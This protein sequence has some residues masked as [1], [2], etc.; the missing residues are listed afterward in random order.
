MCEYKNCKLCPR[1][2]GIDRSKT[3]GACK[4]TDKVKVA[5][6][7]I[8]SYEEP[9]ISGIEGSGTVFFSNCNLR[10]VYCQNFE[11]SRDGFGKEITVERLA[12]IF[13]EQQS[14]GVNNIN[15]VTPTMYVDSI[16]EAI[17]IAKSK[18]LIIPIVYNSS[19]YEKAETIKKLEGYIDVYL[20]DF[21]YATN[22]LA[23]KYSGVNNYVESVIPAIRE[24]IRQAGKPIFNDKGIMTKGVI[25]RHMILPNNVLNTKMVLKKVKEEFKDNTLI[26]VMAQY[27]PSG[28]AA[29]YPEINR[30]ITAEEL[31][32]VENY[33]EEL[34]MDNGYIQEL[35]EHEEEYVPNFDLSNI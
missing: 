16:I 30:K 12:D 20:P 11:I 21:K 6:A 9:C 7:S 25:I 35:G 34:E 14:R 13:I 33:L 18:G 17:K 4:A 23:K 27:F 32:E 26:S 22:R 31:E 8:H 24:M 1:E 28:D 5:L 10:C 3:I 2:C 29:K 19:G 15:L